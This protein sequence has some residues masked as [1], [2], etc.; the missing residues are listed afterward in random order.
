MYNVDWAKATLK[1][2][3]GL[4]LSAALDV[5]RDAAAAEDMATGNSAYRFDGYSRFTAD[6][7][8]A[9]R[10]EGASKVGELVG[11]LLS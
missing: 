9:R 8:G 11:C 6:Y 5:V 1:G 3:D 10:N 7:A 2:K 4:V